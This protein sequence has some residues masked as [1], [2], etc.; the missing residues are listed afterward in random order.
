MP[1]FQLNPADVDLV[2]DALTYV[3][4]HDYPVDPDYVLLHVKL[5]EWRKSLPAPKA[6]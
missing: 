3:L 4:R 6:I 1:S 5:L 2:I